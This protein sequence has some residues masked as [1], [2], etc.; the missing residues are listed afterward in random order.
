MALGVTFCSAIWPKTRNNCR[1][2]EELPGSGRI[3]GFRKNSQYSKNEFRKNCRVRV[4]TN[5]GEGSKEAR[6]QARKVKEGK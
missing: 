4:G 3:A 5:E 6:K 1:V 2:Q